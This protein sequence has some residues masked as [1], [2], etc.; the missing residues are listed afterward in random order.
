MVKSSIQCCALFLV[1]VGAA[2]NPDSDKRDSDSAGGSAGVGNTLSGGATTAAGHVGTLAGASSVTGGTAAVITSGA[3]TSTGG[4]NN[5]A[6]SGTSLA[7]ASTNVA[8]A[9]GS[10]MAEGGAAGIGGNAGLG[11]V[12]GATAVVWVDPATSLSWTVVAATNVAHAQATTYCANL[13]LSG[14]DDWRLPTV[15]ELRSV[16]SGC[17]ATATAGTCAVHN[18]CLSSLCRDDSCGGC[19]AIPEGCYI[20]GPLGS[21]CGFYWSSASQSDYSDNAWGVGFNGAHVSTDL[22]L[23][24]GSARCVR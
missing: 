11:G 16:I 2:C 23:N 4:L 21:D 8:G 19:V 18:S 6:G 17:T 13:V 10:A 3:A 1:I 5:V 14:H 7:G 24:S 9:S 15:D 12:A 20:K 22:K